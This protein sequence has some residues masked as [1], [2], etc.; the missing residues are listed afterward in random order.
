MTLPRRQQRLGD[1]DSIAEGYDRRHATRD[2][3]FVLVGDVKE[4]EGGKAAGG[5]E[6]E[7]H[8]N[9]N[10]N[11]DRGVDCGGNS[12]RGRNKKKKSKRGA[13]DSSSEDVAC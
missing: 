2:I 12:R 11:H 10:G 5:V 3:S 7:Q 4:A 8:E 1:G 13:K 9:V 6:E